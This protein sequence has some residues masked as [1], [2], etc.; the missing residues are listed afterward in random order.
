MPPPS[1]PT[2][3][4]TWAQTTSVRKP[5]SCTGPRERTGQAHNN[6][7]NNTTNDDNRRSV[8]KVLHTPHVNLL[9]WQPAPIPNPCPTQDLQS[10]QPGH[11]GTKDCRADGVHSTRSTKGKRPGNA[12]HY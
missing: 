12:V 1:P 8:H 4:H 6:N 2:A 7:N 3:P 9:C 11:R 10:P 5:P